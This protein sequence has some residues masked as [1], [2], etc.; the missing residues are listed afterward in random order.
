MTTG[1]NNMSRKFL[2]LWC[3]WDYGQDSVIFEDENV[4]KDWLGKQIA[5]ERTDGILSKALEELGFP[6]GL[7]EI[8]DG[9]LAC[10]SLVELID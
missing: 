6:E 10:F 7:E 4:A 1:R 8:F 5:S 3:E 2:K 9:G